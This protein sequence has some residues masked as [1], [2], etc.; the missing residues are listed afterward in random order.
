MKVYVA[1]RSKDGVLT[2]IKVYKDE[3]KIKKYCLEQNEEIIIK[4]KTLNLN[5]NVI[6]TL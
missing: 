2:P 3:E 1:Y 6:L 4:A 5:K